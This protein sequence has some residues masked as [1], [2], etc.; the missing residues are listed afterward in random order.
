VTRGSLRAEGKA[1]EGAASV[2]TLGWI[3]GTR[4]WCSGNPANPMI[5]GQLQHADEPRV[6]QTVEVVRNHEGGTCRVCGRTR[7]KQ[8]KVCGRTRPR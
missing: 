4:S 3:V 7:P 1:L 6:A 2:R 5:G 8:A